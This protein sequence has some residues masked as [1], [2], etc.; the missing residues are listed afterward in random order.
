MRWKLI[1]KSTEYIDLRIASHP[2]N[3]S[4]YIKIAAYAWP[5]SK[6]SAPY[7]NRHQVHNWENSENQS[8]P[9]TRPTKSLSK[10]VQAEYVC[11]FSTPQMKSK[12]QSD[13]VTYQL[14]RW[15]SF[16]H[17]VSHRVPTYLSGKYSA[18]IQIPSFVIQFTY[19]Q[20]GTNMLSANRQPLRTWMGLNIP[21]FPGSGITRIHSQPYRAVF[22]VHLYG[23]DLILII[24]WNFRDRRSSTGRSLLEVGSIE[25]QD[26]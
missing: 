20:A 4:N 13:W 11:R 9:V 18:S 7:T 26:A 19:L 25:S 24:V 21:A 17:R 2:L 8:S 3:P 5:R 6:G 22:E 23:R 10:L 16:S 12:A 15:R 1:S 14:V